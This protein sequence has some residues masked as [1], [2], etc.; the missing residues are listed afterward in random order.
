[1]KK[2][3][4][5]MLLAAAV[6]LLPMTVFA[7]NCESVAI[8]NTTLWDDG[9]LKSMDVTFDWAPAGNEHLY[10][11]VL[12][13]HTESNADETEYWFQYDYYSH[14]DPDSVESSIN[15]FA[16]YRGISWYSYGGNGST[17]VNGDNTY[18]VTFAKGTVPLSVDRNYSFVMFNA[19]DGT[20]YRPTD[21]LGTLKCASSALSFENTSGSS[22]NVEVTVTI[23]DIIATY[24]GFPMTKD[25]DLYWTNEQG[26]S[27]YYFNKL[28]F[29]RYSDAKSLQ[30]S[31]TVDV[32]PDGDHYT[33]SN[34]TVTYTF[35]MDKDSG[36]LSAITVSGSADT[37]Y[38]GTY[39]APPAKYT[40]AN[41]T[42][43]AHGSIELGKTSA[44]EGDLVTITVTPAEGYRLKTLAAE[45]FDGGQKKNCEIV[46]IK[47]I[48]FQMPAFDVTV[49]AEFE[50]I[51]HPH[52][53]TYTA[54]SGRITAACSED[55]GMKPLTLTLTAPASLVSDGEPKSFTFADGEAS[56]WTEAGLELPDIFYYVKQNGQTEYMPL[57]GTL[58]AAGDYMA[59]VTVDGKSAQ[60]YFSIEVPHT[61]GPVKVDGQAATET[62]AGWKDYYECGCGAL[63]ED[64]NGTVPIED[65]A[66]WKAQGGN[67]YIAKLETPPKT[68]DHSALAL[69]AALTA[70]SAMGL[71]VC[72]VPGKKRTG[73]R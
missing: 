22:T 71:G 61:H 24:E 19:P 1:M 65:L 34:G 41:G 44:A 45:Y 8:T 49:T 50:P 72:L 37:K 55:C 64:E 36:V 9:S 39:S 12:G 20:G 48:C 32:T 11:A 3:V 68:G 31:M 40:V 28:L 53:L 7:R 60:V 42:T 62:A 23:A 30:Q 66:A 5:S 4:L 51:P 33:Y 35:V 6:L 58:K 47:G 14:S 2:R 38:N 15:D 54:D 73:A 69:W 25:T 63:F 17:P 46:T 57:L 70:V 52:V 18:N 43:D 16:E 27:C 29:F 13:E 21:P 59:Q 10:I 67:G 56:A 26:T